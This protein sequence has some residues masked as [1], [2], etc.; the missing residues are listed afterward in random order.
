MIRRVSHLTLVLLATAALLA[1]A[2]LAGSGKPKKHHSGGSNCVSAVC[3]YHEGPVGLGGVGGNGPDVPLSAPA[4]AML[5]K[6]GGKQTRVLLNISTKRA[7]GVRP[8]LTGEAA[9]VGDVNA[10]GAFLAALDLGPG[11]IA[12]FVTLLAGAV[13]F[14]LG[15]ALRRR[16]LGH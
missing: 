11:P 2:A 8:P 7:F 14:G 15:G 6:Y 5:E 1:P 13:A 9:S 12:L 3:V 16:R 4:A 10:P